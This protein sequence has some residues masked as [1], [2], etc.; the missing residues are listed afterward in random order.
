MTSRGGSR[1]QFAS[2]D[3]SMLCFRL[4]IGL[5][6]GSREETCG[7]RHLLD[8][9]GRDGNSQECGSEL[10]SA[11]PRAWVA[12]ISH[13]LVGQQTMLT[14]GN[15]PPGSGRAHVFVDI[16]GEAQSSLRNQA[17]GAAAECLGKEGVKPLL[18][19]PYEITPNCVILS[20]YYSASSKSPRRQAAPSAVCPCPQFGVACDNY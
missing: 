7:V 5:V 4:P 2:L 13:E 14:E 15:S 16:A 18:G 19:T 12:V 1:K 6:L 10:H 11:P 8:G 9:G 3:V 20:V 17:P